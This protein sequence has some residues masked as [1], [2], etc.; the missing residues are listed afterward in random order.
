MESHFAELAGHANTGYGHEMEYFRE[1]IAPLVDGETVVHLGKVNRRQKLELFDRALALVFPIMWREPFGLVMIEAV[2]AGVPILAYRR[3]SVP[4]V[5]DEGVTGY[6]GDSVEELV[7]L[8]PAT[9]ALDRNRLRRYAASRFCHEL[10]ADRYDAVYTNVLSS[11]TAQ[12]V[13]DEA[14]AI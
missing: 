14:Q 1:H 12:K 9:L 2:E 4:E 8:L 3:G 11:G 10:M 7:S 5:V 13:G 6:Y